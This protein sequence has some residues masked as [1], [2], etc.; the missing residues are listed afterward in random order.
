M[1]YHTIPLFSDTL[2]AM[3]SGNKWYKVKYLGNNGS[4]N[5]YF[6]DKVSNISI[7][8]NVNS[9]SSDSNAVIVSNVSI[10]H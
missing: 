6:T 10:V 1:V 9:V 3:C 7:V 4:A 5:Y 2:R 8:C